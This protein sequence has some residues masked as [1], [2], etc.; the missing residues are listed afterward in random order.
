V[1]YIKKVIS[2]FENF[3]ILEGRLKTQFSDRRHRWMPTKESF[4]RLKFE[5]GRNLRMTIKRTLLLYTQKQVE[6]VVHPNPQRA[7]SDLDNLSLI[8]LID[9]DHLDATT[10]RIWARSERM[11]T[12]HDLDRDQKNLINVTW[13]H[14]VACKLHDV[15]SHLIEIK[16]EFT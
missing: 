12:E 16:I 13:W 14:N 3:V 10:V 5:V 7:R 6:Q 11:L 4:F 2:V 15:S 9:R 1:W 8:S